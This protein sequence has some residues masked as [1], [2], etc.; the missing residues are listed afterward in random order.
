MAANG[1]TELLAEV[2]AAHGGLD[3]WQGFAMV[4]TDLVTA[5]QLWGIK[6]IDQDAETRNVTATLDKE[7]LSLAPFGDPSW[8][9][10]F[11][12]DRVAIEAEDG[13]VIVERQDPRDSFAGHDMNSPWD[14]LHRAYWNG[15][16]LWTYLT[17][18]FLLAMPGF[19]VLEI[20]SL[21]E[22][23]EVWRGLRARFPQRVASHSQEQDFYFGDDLLLRRHDYHVDVAGGFAAA[24]YVSEFVDTNGIRVPTRRRAYLRDEHLR[25]I[26]DRLLI[27]IDFDR[28]RFEERG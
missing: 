20:E 13:T 12:P 24:H 1:A 2:L 15:Y 21:T 28:V 26:Q 14:P 25:P 10:V 19:E 22:G 9:M 17:T 27:A 3:R 16:T 8:R 18:P 23:T 6:G 4:R 5:G 7:W 11:T